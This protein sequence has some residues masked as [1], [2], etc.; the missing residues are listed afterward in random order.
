MY[1]VLNGSEA[2]NCRYHEL[3]L[4]AALRGFLLCHEKRDVIF[5]TG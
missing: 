5:M 4:S 3:T 2:I 1:Q